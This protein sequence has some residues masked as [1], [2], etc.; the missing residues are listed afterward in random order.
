MTLVLVAALLVVLISVV[1]VMRRLL[2][3]EWREH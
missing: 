3:D 1:G 2:R